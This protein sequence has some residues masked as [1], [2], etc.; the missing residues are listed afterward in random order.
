M[1]KN[2]D[3]VLYWDGGQGVCGAELV[4]QHFPV[5]MA[6]KGRRIVVSGGGDAALAKLCLL[7][8]T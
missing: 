8:K 5:F 6:V 3:K 2:R 4:M 7:L 1:A